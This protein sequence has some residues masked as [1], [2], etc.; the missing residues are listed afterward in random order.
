MAPAS[1]LSATL[2]A[3]LV[4]LILHQPAALT[5]SGLKIPDLISRKCIQ[6]FQIGKPLTLRYYSACFP[7]RPKA[8]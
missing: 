5:G 1:E 7:V 3:I 4:Q 2:Q 6:V 8:G